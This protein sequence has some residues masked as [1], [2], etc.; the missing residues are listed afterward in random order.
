MFFIN[1]QFFFSPKKKDELSTTALGMTVYLCIPFFTNEVVRSE[2]HSDVVFNKI[3]W[4]T[5]K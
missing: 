2:V 5:G 1:K 4:P 3:L